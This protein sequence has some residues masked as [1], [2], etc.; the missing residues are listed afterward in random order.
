MLRWMVLFWH[1]Y[2]YHLL[3]FYLLSRG[4]KSD[5]NMMIQTAEVITVFGI[6]IVCDVWHILQKNVK[7][8]KKN[9]ELEQERQKGTPVLYG[10]VIQVTSM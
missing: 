7:I 10:S 5:D 9:N 3:H 6:T 4:N 8:E 2:V 1:C